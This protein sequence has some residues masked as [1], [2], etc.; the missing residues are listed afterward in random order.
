MTLANG[1]LRLFLAD[2]HPI[3]LGG[4]EKLLALRPNYTIV[5]TATDGRTAWE[6]I[7]QL[8]PDVALLDINMPE[9]CGLEVL[10]HVEGHGLATRVILL[11]A[12]AADSQ[13]KRAVYQGAW[14]IMLKDFAADVLLECIDTVAGGTRWLPE[15][16]L[17]PALER[18]EARQRSAGTISR[19]L[20]GR[21]QE[22][23]QLVAAGLSNKEIARR[24][25]LSEGTV[26]IHLH[27]IYGKLEVS[28]RTNLATLVHRSFDEQ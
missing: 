24:L 2:D 14:G 25:S 8:E 12:S 26:K 17:G 1:A 20:T 4:L 22:V 5:G 18:E 6:L 11:T 13:L 23:A 10:E 15:D 19:L 9:L 16:L 7:Q 3:V 27:N 21:E 28:N